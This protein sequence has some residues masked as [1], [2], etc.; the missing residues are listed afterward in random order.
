MDALH[1]RSVAVELQRQLLVPRQVVLLALLY[2][3][4][5]FLVDVWRALVHHKLVCGRLPLLGGTVVHHQS[6]AFCTHRGFGR[7]LHRTKHHTHLVVAVGHLHGEVE[8]LNAIGCGRV[9]DVIA[10]ARLSVI[11]GLPLRH[12]EVVGL[13]K[14]CHRQQ[15]QQR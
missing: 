9:Q 13:A 6:A 5:G 10:I 2:T 3:H 8:W 4:I 11:Y 15:C 12:V 14:G 1:G 7:P